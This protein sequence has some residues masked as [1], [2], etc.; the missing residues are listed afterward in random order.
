MC[1]GLSV[2]RWHAF[3]LTN[4]RR[5]PEKK[6]RARFTD[7]VPH[8]CRNTPRRHDPSS[9]ALRGKVTSWN[10]PNRGDGARYAGV[11]FNPCLRN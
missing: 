9:T 11:Y 6:V 10:Q 3:D 2:R 5:L 1:F 8:R 7:A 4:A